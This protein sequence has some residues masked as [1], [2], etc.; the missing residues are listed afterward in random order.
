MAAE[1]EQQDIYHIEV[2]EEYLDDD[3]ISYEEEAFMQG[4]L[5]S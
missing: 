3:Q 4:Y 5:L 2:V 1:A